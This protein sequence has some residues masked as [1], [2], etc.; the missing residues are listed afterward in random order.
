MCEIEVE[1][2]HSDRASPFS[3]KAM[4]T[5]HKPHERK[6]QEDYAGTRQQLPAREQ[7]QNGGVRMQLGR[8][9]SHLTIA[10]HRIA[11]FIFP[12]H[13]HQSKGRVQI[14]KKIKREGKKFW[15]EM[16]GPGKQPL[17]SST[18]LC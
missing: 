1:A 9:H 10:S 4:L 15:R 5:F 13:V 12:F 8:S 14:K 2:A 16:K 18:S 17:T 11:S 6:K 7:M 3:Q